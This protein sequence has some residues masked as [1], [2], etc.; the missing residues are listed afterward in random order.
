YHDIGKGRGGDHS[1]LGAIDARKFCQRHGLGRTDTDLVAWLVQNHLTM[2][3]VSQK[4]DISDPE[5]I[6]QFAEHMGD[7]THL[8]YLFALTVADINATNPTLW[9]AWRSS[10]LRQLYTGTKRALRRGL[11]NPVDKQVLIEKARADAADILEYRGFTEEELKD[12]W[13]E[14]TEDYFLRE[15]T[16][17]IA[18]HTE[19]IAGHHDRDQPLVLVRST[20][21]SS[22]ANATQIFIHARSGVHLFSTICAELEQLDLSVHDARIYRTSDGMSL[23]TFSV[24]DS[25]GKSLAE[26][27]KRIKFISDQLTLALAG[28]AHAPEIPQRRTP[29]QVK[30]FSIPTETKM[31][32]DD[33]NNVSILEVATP[34][35]PGLLARVGKIFVEF[36]LELQ[37]AK[38]QTLGERVEDVFFLTDES[39]QAISDPTVCEA[40]QH[41]IRSELDEQAAA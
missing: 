7:E 27:N 17:D 32:L 24:L 21:D 34:D 10:L 12:L 14:R 38:I 30:S 39:Q 40:I 3:A 2:S 20:T 11:E 29:R 22:V 25:S 33:A 9:N 16:E 36:K 35:R 15:R 37:A 6:Q 28:T 23:D 26:D 4:K 1:E 13:R 31:T 8:D 19:A 41:A 5:I 18:W